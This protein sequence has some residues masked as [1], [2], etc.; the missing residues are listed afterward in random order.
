MR[1]S[2]PTQHNYVY[3][4]LQTR[5]VEVHYACRDE[6]CCLK[7]VLPGQSRRELYCPQCQHQC[8]EGACLFARPDRLAERAVEQQM[9]R[10]RNIAV[11][12]SKERDRQ[13][14]HETDY[15]LGKTCAYPGCDRPISNRATYCVQHAAT[16]QHEQRRRQ[17][18]LAGAEAV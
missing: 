6:R 13:R 12:S 18:E 11:T 14:H 1:L 5:I 10:Y 16:V 8:G 17:Q 7:P 2:M 15:A 3:S 9:L 4:S